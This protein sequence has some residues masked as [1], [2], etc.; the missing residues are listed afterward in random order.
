ME[1][2]PSFPKETGGATLK[3]ISVSNDDPVL[4]RTDSFTFCLRFYL[5]VLGTTSNQKRGNVI[6]IASWGFIK[7]WAAYPNREVGQYMF[8]EVICLIMGCYDPVILIAE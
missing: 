8:Q 6:Q 5:E 3:N 1:Y 7:L 4:N 2:L